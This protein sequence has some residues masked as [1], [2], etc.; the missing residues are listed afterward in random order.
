MCA[1]VPVGV[2]LSVSVCVS[3]SVCMLDM[4]DSMSVY[5]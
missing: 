1:C 2:R 5:V 4:R 3:V